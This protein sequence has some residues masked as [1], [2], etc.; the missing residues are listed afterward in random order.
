MDWHIDVHESAGSTQ[1]LLKDLAEGG[2]PEGTVIQALEQSGGRG[3]HGRSWISPRGNLYMSLLLRPGCAVNLAGQV[4]LFTAVALAKTI[5]EFIEDDKSLTLKWPNDILLA[6]KKCGG[7][8][9]DSDIDTRGRVSW[10]A[11][12]TGINIESAPQQIGACLKDYASNAIKIDEFRDAA[13]AQVAKY[14]NQWKNAGFDAI[15]QE[16]LTLAHKP[17]QPMSVKIGTQELSGTFYGLDETGNLLLQDKDNKI[18]T[19]SSGDVYT[20]VG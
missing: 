8:L 10:L 13:L 11:V 4:S 1:N 20:D 18:Q 7:I 2:A 9:L 3:R 16:W 12:G 19:I 6:G 15:K 14:Y 17:G 5:G